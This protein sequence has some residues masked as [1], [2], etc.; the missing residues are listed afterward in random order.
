M[1]LGKASAELPGTTYS[2]SLPWQPLPSGSQTASCS[3]A[4]PVMLRSY[5]N[6]IPGSKHQGSPVCIAIR[7]TTNLPSYPGCSPA[8]PAAL[9]Y[10]SSTICCC[11]TF[12]TTYHCSCTHQQTE[13]QRYPHSTRGGPTQQ[14]KSANKN[15]TTATAAH[16]L[17]LFLLNRLE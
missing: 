3:S 9:S 14:G 12:C 2:H 16:Q 13:Q 4:T 15:A 6:T 17:T 1:P 5:L 10:P 7:Q 11:T 8:A